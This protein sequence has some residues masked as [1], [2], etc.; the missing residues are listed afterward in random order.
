VDLGGLELFLRATGPLAVVDL[1]T[2][3]L[4]NDPD[5]E[6]LEFGA[7]LLDPGSDE[8]TTLES[9]VRPLG[10]HVDV[11]CHADVA[12]E[13]GRHA[14][15]QDEANPAFAERREHRLGIEIAASHRRRRS[16]DDRAGRSA[17]RVSH[18]KGA[19]RGCGA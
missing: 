13:N 8:I 15:D 1:E 17:P 3:G 19:L 5:S 6:V 2:T 7:V 11:H 14:A 10:D 9:L 12:V 4:S 18:P 16:R